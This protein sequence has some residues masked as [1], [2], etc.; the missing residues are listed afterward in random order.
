MGTCT[1]RSMAAVIFPSCI[2]STRVQTF[3]APDHN[4]DDRLAFGAGFTTFENST[5]GSDQFRTNSLR[6]I[7]ADPTRPGTVY[8][9]DTV[10]NADNSTDVYSARSS[11]YGV[12]WSSNIKVGN[13]PA[14]VLDDVNRGTPA[15]GSS[16]KEVIGGDAFAR[17]S[18]GANGDIAVIWY[19]TRVDPANA[20][21]NVFG[22]TSIDGGKTFSKNFRVSDTTFDPNAGV[23]TDAAG[24]DDYYLGDFIGLTV[25]G[26]TAYATWTDTRNGNQDIEESSFSVTAPPAALNDR[27][28]SNDTIDTATDFGSVLQSTYPKLNIPSGDSDWFTFSPTATGTIS[29]AATQANASG[30]LLNL[31]LYDSTGGTLLASGSAVK[32]AAGQVTGVSLATAG[33]SGTDYLLHVTPI[34]KG[35][36][37]SLELSGLTRN[38]GTQVYGQQNGSLALGDQDDFLLKA[39]AAGTLQVQLAPGS[40]ATGS[41]ALQILARAINRCSPRHRFGQ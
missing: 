2:R 16:S 36:T 15:T 35:A 29:I 27:F 22:T 28:E 30:Q 7:V 1:F 3:A 19:D 12:T 34:G 33:S 8:A 6:D 26:D 25:A 32:N 5:L 41:I 23:F 31:Q 24:R 40:N 14:D 18:V 37:Y 13:M 21:L 9:V 38:L 39:A 4:S 17:L 20:L 10:V 11:D